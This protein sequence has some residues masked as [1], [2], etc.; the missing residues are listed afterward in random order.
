MAEPKHIGEIIG[1]ILAECMKKTFE[2]GAT[3]MTSVKQHMSVSKEGEL[4]D[5][6]K[7]NI[8]VH[9]TSD[10]QVIEVNIQP[11]SKE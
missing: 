5:E 11:T 1:E 8:I 7:V 9:P 2:S 6:I 10:I 4:I 3:V